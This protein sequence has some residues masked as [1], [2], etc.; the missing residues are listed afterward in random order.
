MHF[1]RDSIPSFARFEFLNQLFIQ[2]HPL[3]YIVIPCPFIKG[4]YAQVKFRLACLEG[5]IPALAKLIGLRSRE[6]NTFTSF[7]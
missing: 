5:D 3:E 2:F 7:F 1:E 6:N 4:G